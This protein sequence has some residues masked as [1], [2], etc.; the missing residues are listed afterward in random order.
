MSQSKLSAY[1]RAAVS[2]LLVLVPLAVR[3]DAPAVKTAD[4]ALAK[5]AYI[6]LVG[7]SKYSDPQIL[8]RD[9]PED[10]AKS[11]YDLFTDKRYLG[12]DQEHIRLLLGSPDPQRASEPA[13][14]ENILKALHWAVG[15]ANKDDMVIFAFSGEG[16]PLADRTCYFASDS[17]FKDRA[18]NALAAAEIENALDN[19]MKSDRFCAFVDVNFKGFSVPKDSAPDMN[20]QKYYREFLGET[21]DK[22]ERA[23][24]RGSS[25]ARRAPTR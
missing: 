17:T 13:T 8:S 20:T 18:K 16:A 5:H 19:K 7:I 11:Y 22:E 21:K 4:D 10:D 3:A 2:S 1:W 15:K 14:H 25:P 6:V 9:H 24:P 12:V 23:I